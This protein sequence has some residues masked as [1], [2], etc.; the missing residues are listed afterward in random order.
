MSSDEA[1]DGSEALRVD[2][3]RFTGDGSD[4]ILLHWLRHA[5][6]AIETSSP[7]TLLSSLQTLHAFF[8][9]LLLPSPNPTLPKPG[10]PIRHLVTRCVVKLHRRV[11][12]RSLFDFVQALVKGVADG[13]GKNMNAAENVARVASWYCI[14][15]VLKELGANVRCISSRPSRCPSHTCR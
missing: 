1:Q 11:E 14:G 9:R 5:E 3:S 10:R 2:E 15:E 4:L 7:S 13:G 6:Q 8:L 12:S